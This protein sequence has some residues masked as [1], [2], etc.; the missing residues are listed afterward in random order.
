MMSYDSRVKVGKGEVG[1]FVIWY[2]KINVM[3][4]DHEYWVS[5]TE[6]KAIV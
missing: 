4:D 5:R 1:V 3:A 2:E 6:T